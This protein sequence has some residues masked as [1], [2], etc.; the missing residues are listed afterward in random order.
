MNFESD[1]EHI[2][3]RQF[4]E[5]GIC[6]K[7]NLDVRCLSARY[8]EMLNRRIV[9][10]P[11]EVLFSEEIRDSLGKLTRETR[12]KQR[13]KA[14]EAWEAVFFIRDLLTEGQNLNCFLSERVDS[15]TGKRSRD[16]LLWDFGMHHFHLSK[17]VEAS[18]FVKRSDYLLFA[19]ITQKSAYFVDVRPHNDPQSLGWVRQE[20]LNIVHSNWPELIESNVLRGVTGNVIT[21]EEKK[22]L[23]RKN[24]NHVADLGGSAVAPF[25]GG[26]MGDG[27]SLACRWLA[28]KL[29]HEIGRHQA[30]FDTQPSDLRS[31]LEDKGLEAGEMEFELVL[32]DGLNPSDK[33]IDSL[34]EDQCLSRDLCQ[35]GCVVVE[36][37]T[38]SPIV[39]S[40]E[41]A[42]EAGSGD[43]L[44]HRRGNAAAWPSR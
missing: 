16:G 42:G 30:Y 21:D 3:K 27:S 14:T 8:L 19:I 17:E 11:R 20:L 28:Q 40:L 18:G 38:R 43:T 32:L 23:R 1:L 10:V 24:T 33:L 15:A 39:V 36:R 29:L 22:E 12:V 35:M 13:E 37:T 25:G 31:A 7:D 26:T 2:I 41:H 6:Y 9:P 34:R 5:H 44:R 4:D